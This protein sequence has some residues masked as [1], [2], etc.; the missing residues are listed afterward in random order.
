MGVASGSVGGSSSGSASE[1]PSSSSAKG[2][3][4]QL[5]LKSWPSADPIV[6]Q[7]PLWH[8]REEEGGE[9]EKDGGSNDGGKG[10]GAGAGEAAAAKDDEVPHFA[11]PP[12]TIA[13]RRRRLPSAKQQL[14]RLRSYIQEHYPGIKT[15]TLQL[16]K[17]RG[18]GEWRKSERRARR[19][20]ICGLLLLVVVLVS[21]SAPHFLSVCLFVSLSR[22]I[23]L[24]L[25]LSLSRPLSRSLD[26]PVFPP[27]ISFGGG[28]AITY[29]ALAKKLSE[30]EGTEVRVYS[31]RAGNMDACSL[32]FYERCV[33]F[34]SLSLS[35][36]SISP[37]SLSL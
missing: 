2:V 17:I 27:N 7:N 1:G 12:T 20:L 21:F 19:V 5:N 16:R 29:F 23:S 36:S 22:L 32:P 9:Q 4:T 34:L 37:L 3:L 25:S 33:F 10:A 6:P 15:P 8:E 11:T 26:S 13:R 14:G 31:P 35:T 30:R 28:V 24:S 18:T